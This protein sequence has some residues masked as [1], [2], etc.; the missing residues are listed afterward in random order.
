MMTPSATV[1]V[2][3]RHRRASSAARSISMRAH[4][5]A[6]QPQRRAAVLDRLA[7]GGLALV[8]RQRGVGRDRS[9]RAPSGR[10]SSS[11]AICQSA[12]RMPCPS[13][14][15]PVKRW[16]CRRRRCAP[17]RRACGWCRGCRAAARACRRLAPAVRRDRARTR[18]TMP[19]TALAKPRRVRI[20]A[21]MV[22][23]SPSLPMALVAAAC[24]H[25]RSRR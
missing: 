24:R 18:A 21:F 16:R 20:G 11:A 19:P 8:G 5:G 13:S 7:A 25:A 22:R 4:L 15:L 23:A 10:S 1:S 12:V 3:G 6:G 2:A 17:R 14:T 9:S